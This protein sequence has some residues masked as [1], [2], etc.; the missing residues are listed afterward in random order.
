LQPQLQTNGS[1]QPN[2]PPRCDRLAFTRKNNALDESQE[3]REASKRSH[4]LRAFALT[5]FTAHNF[6][7]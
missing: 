2:S 6:R 1:C 7:R 4:I 3:N 5:G